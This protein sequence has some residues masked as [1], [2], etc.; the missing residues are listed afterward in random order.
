MFPKN[1][2]ILVV[3]DMKGIR[4]L[5]TKL[6]KELGYAT[7]Q[8]AENGEMALEIISKAQTS[9]PFGL[10]ICDLRMPKMDGLDLLSK[11][12]TDQAF[13]KLPFVMLTAESEKENV[14]KAIEIG[15]NEYIIKPTT[16]PILSKKLEKVWKS[17]N[18]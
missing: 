18:P 13:A 4:V 5:I 1:T 6:L 8:E 14:V 11:L 9:E 10:I 15:V 12:R 3:D 7:V 2:K 17:L 16:A